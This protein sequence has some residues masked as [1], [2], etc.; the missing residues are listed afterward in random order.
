MK[1]VDLGNTE[2]AWTNGGKTGLAGLEHRR[3]TA[4]WNRMYLVFQGSSTPAQVLIAH[5]DSKVISNF[6]HVV[7]SGVLFDQETEDGLEAVTTPLRSWKTKTRIQDVLKRSL[8]S[9]GQFKTCPKQQ[10]IAN[11]SYMP[12]T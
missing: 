5:V 2:A 4:K 12:A 1:S 3:G 9:W 7:I 8:K 11:Q 10:P 6:G